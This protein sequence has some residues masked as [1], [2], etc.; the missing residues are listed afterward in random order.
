MQYFQ[1]V[2]IAGFIGLTA[3]QSWLFSALAIR[4]APALGCLDHPDTDCKTHMQAMPVLGGVAIYVALLVSTV[5]YFVG[6]ALLG[7]GGWDTTSL[8]L[9]PETV[10]SI[11][12]MMISGGLLCLL[13]AIDDRYALR[14]LTKYTCQLIAL[15]PFVLFGPVVES[16]F[17]LDAGG[18]IPIY[19]AIPLT[20]FVMTIFINA[21]NLLDGLDGVAGAVATTIFLTASGVALGNGHITTVCICFVCCAVVVGF[22]IHNW[23]PAKIFLGDSGSMTIGFLL[24]AVAIEGAVKRT[25]GLTF[26]VPFLLMSI[27][28]FDTLM[29]ISRRILTG[30]SIGHGDRSHIH[31][32]L[33]TLGLRPSWVATAMA[34]FCAVSG[35]VVVLSVT[36]NTEWV[37]LL[38]CGALICCLIGGKIFGYHELILLIRNIRN[39]R[40][41]PRLVAEEVHQE[42]LVEEMEFH[43]TRACTLAWE[44]LCNYLETLHFQT[45]NVIHTH[46][47]TISERVLLQWKKTPE[48]CAATTAPSGEY[49]IIITA[50]HAINDEEKITLRATGE[51]GTLNATS[52]LP[53]LLSFVC[54]NLGESLSKQKA[55]ELIISFGDVNREKET[56]NTTER[57]QAA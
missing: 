12:L 49:E 1:F 54:R 14:A 21:F 15:A 16:V 51:A 40:K 45:V 57:K 42:C 32:I 44:R 50:A 41:V 47:D 6:I 26:I 4:I 29:A 56:A 37:A 5:E 9:P 17:F 48:L 24:G 8:T 35:G 30:K 55:E 18:A 36:Y 46:V 38:G 2:I 3:A 13:G 22:L 19:V 10:R 33:H 39:I 25:T 43:D 34:L 11:M 31:H 52:G 20:F 27:P 23:P 28:C 7:W 53:H